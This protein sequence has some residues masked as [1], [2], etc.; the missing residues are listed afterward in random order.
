MQKKKRTKQLWENGRERKEHN[1]PRPP[2]LAGQYTRCCKP[3]NQSEPKVENIGYAEFTKQT[4][5]TICIGYGPLHPSP[6]KQLQELCHRR[7]EYKQ[8]EL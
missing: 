5:Q 4:L 3:N 1:T 7:N 6:M 2:K 8:Y